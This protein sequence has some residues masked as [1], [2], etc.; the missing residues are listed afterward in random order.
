MKSSWRR[1]STPGCAQVGGQQVAVAAKLHTDAGEEQPPLDDGRPTPALSRVNGYLFG[2][3]HLRNSWDVLDSSRR[4]PATPAAEI[5]RKHGPHVPAA[6]A[7]LIGRP[8]LQMT[9][10]AVLAGVDAAASGGLISRTRPPPGVRRC[11]LA[12]LPRRPASLP[13][14]HAAWTTS[15]LLVTETFGLLSV[16]RHGCRSP[17]VS[18]FLDLVLC[19]AL[20]YC[21]TEC[22]EK[23]EWHADKLR[24]LQGNA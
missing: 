6:S 22:L 19:D 8:V 3:V 24:V 17:D 4:H 11:P 12:R 10:R 15:G 13:P 21:R 7:S 5:L 2:L 9:R 1:S 23:S 18:Q 16:L 14:R 20:V